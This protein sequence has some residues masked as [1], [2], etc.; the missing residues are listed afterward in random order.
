LCHF[1]ESAHSSKSGGCFKATSTVMTST[2]QRKAMA[3]LEVG[4]LVLTADSDGSL[5]FSPVILFLD[6][7]PDSRRQFYAIETE[8]GVTLTVT[9]SHLVYADLRNDGFKENEISDSENFKAVFA[10]RVREG[11]YILVQRD[12]AMS[13]SRVTNIETKIFSGVFAPLTSS[14]NLVVDGALA[15]CYAVLE[16]QSVSHAAFAPFRWSHA[17]TGWLDLSSSRVVRSGDSR[18]NEPRTIGIHWYADILYSLAQL[19]MPERVR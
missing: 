11:D 18:Q 2:G 3:D 14:G 16:D 13:P 15:S 9:P 1:S 7:D 17:I 5:Q 8:S 12:G 6:R 4:D 10:G 19:V